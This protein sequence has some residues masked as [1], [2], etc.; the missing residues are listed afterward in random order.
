MITNENNI[1]KQQQ[2]NKKKRYACEEK[3][4]QHLNI[5]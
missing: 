3:T 1:Y 4:L 2:K 5:A